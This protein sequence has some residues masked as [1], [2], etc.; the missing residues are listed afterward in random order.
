[1]PIKNDRNQ[2]FT[3]LPRPE[4]VPYRDELFQDVLLFDI[5]VVTL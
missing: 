4:Q 1:M 2:K 3:Q 5:S